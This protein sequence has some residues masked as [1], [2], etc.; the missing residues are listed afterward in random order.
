MALQNVWITFWVT[1]LSICV[2]I[3]LFWSSALTCLL[4]NQM[5][6]SNSGLGEETLV[7]SRYLND[8]LFMNSLVCFLTFIIHWLNQI[9]LYLKFSVPSYHIYLHTA[10]FTSFYQ[11]LSSNKKNKFKLRRNFIL[12]DYCRVWGL[13]Q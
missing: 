3:V 10:I 5:N 2:M 1:F 12:K 8:H 13:L 9:I 4:F 6:L 7:Y 11:L